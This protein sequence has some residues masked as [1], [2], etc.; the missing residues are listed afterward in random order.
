M[1]HKDLFYLVGGLNHDKFKGKGYEDMAFFLLAFRHGCYAVQVYHMSNRKDNDWIV[2]CK[3]HDLPKHLRVEMNDE[4]EGGCDE[5][6]KEKS[7][8]KFRLLVERRPMVMRND[9]NFDDL[10]GETEKLI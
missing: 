7:Y 1:F 2:N 10:V 8:K 4:W 3:D 5:K 6:A 9:I